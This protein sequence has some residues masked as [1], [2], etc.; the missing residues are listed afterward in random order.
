MN[1]QTQTAAITPP[2]TDGRTTSR[3]VQVATWVGISA[4]LGAAATLVREDVEP[5]QGAIEG[6]AIGA[7]YLIGKGIYRTF[8]D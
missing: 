1:G 7:L 2:A 3:V 5:K 8:T 4:A 6:A